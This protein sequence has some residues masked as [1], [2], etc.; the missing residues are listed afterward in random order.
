MDEI[1]YEYEKRKEQMNKKK[2][3]M[4]KSLKKENKNIF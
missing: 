2:I 4:E 3:N 1:K